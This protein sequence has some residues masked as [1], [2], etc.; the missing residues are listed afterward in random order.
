MNTLFADFILHPGGIVAWLVV[1]LLAGWS[2]GFVMKGAGYGLIGDIAAGLV[3]ALIGG[4]LF[5][6]FTFGDVGFWGSFVIAFIGAC[7]LIVVVR[8]VALKRTRL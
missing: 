6:F 5:G 8:Y 4:F 2:A 7:I 3:G 1:G